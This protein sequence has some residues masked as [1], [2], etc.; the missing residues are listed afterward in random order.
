MFY[1]NS[2]IRIHSVSKCKV[3]K[4]NEEVKILPHFLRGTKSGRYSPENF[5]VLKLTITLV[6][7]LQCGNYMHKIIIYYVKGRFK[8]SSYLRDPSSSSSSPCICYSR[9]RLKSTLLYIYIKAS[10]SQF[11]FCPMYV[12]I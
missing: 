6:T 5:L 8:S 4:E 11:I 10:L 2:K 7:C 3:R 9:E 12:R 1:C